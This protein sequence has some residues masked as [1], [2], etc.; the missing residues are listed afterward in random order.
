MEYAVVIHEAEEGGYW[1]EVPV[2]EG[3]C[4]AQGETIEEVLADV[5]SAIESHID[6]LREDGQRVPGGA[7]IIIA[8][9]RTPGLGPTWAGSPPTAGATYT[10][11]SERMHSI[12]L[13]TRPACGPRITVWCTIE[14]W[15]G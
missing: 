3:C 2:L 15:L 12:G 13:S 7:G 11:P 1:A 4:F 10:M 8:T 9:V 5:R 6:A 14:Q